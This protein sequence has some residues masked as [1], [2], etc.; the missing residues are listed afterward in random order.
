MKKI[1]IVG[2]GFV[3]N[4]IDYGFSTNV[5]KFLVD[6]KL[7]TTLFDLKSFNPDFIFI[8]VPTP[9]S[10]NGDQD[11]TII[12][13]VLLEISK[14]F[15]DVT[16]IVKSTVL[17]NTLIKFSKLIKHL[18]YNPEFLKEK[19]ANI[20][21][22]SS[23]TLILGGKAND[24]NNVA[25]LYKNY[26]DCEINNIYKTDIVSA[27]LAKYAI[28]TFLAT[29]V[30]FFNQLKD[31]YMNLAP[32]QEWNNFI[33]IVAS[34]KRIG[35]SH[36]KVPGDDGMFGF[37]GSCFPK[38]TSALLYLSKSLNEEFSMLKEVIKIN[39]KIQTK[40]NKK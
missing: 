31:I 30:I 8:C 32:K 26:S 28:N 36:M 29:K 5:E 40:N 25:K 6:P 23:N 2:C 34:D 16:I 33:E 3:G 15:E 38:D 18:V 10:D 17:P 14:S 12:E 35:K 7:G 39:N 22:V 19:T 20:D 24:I 13:D 37:D 11:I 4:A 27:S 21:F 1:G 9:M